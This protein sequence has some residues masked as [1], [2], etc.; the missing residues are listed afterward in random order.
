V[1]GW[2][3]LLWGI[4]LTECVVAVTPDDAVLCG[5]RGRRFR[6]ARGPHLAGID[7]ARG[8]FVLP[9]VPASSAFIASGDSWDIADLLD[10]V[11]RFTAAT[12]LLSL[13]AT[14]LGAA[15]LVITPALIVTSRIESVLLPWASV[16]LALDV[17]V[18]VLFVRARRRLPAEQRPLKPLVL[19]IASPIAA[20]RLPVTLSVDLLRGFDPVAAMIALARDDDALVFARRAW[21]DEPGDRKMIEKALKKREL[22]DRLLAPPPHAD[23]AASAYCPRCH[24]EYSG[25]A[26]SCADCESIGLEPFPAAS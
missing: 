5:R 9:P 15:L 24:Q 1:W 6:G 22:F 12:R 4:Y 16:L 19:A 14:L 18:I 10:R 7:A 3:L 8:W 23:R 26:E 21:F 25:A 2:L 13:M 17:A 11:A 20:I